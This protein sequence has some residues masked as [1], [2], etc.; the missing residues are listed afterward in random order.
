MAWDGS[1]LCGTSGLAS[2]FRKYLTFTQGVRIVRSFQT[3]LN[4]EPLRPRTLARLA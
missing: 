2:T 4:F 3:G 1:V